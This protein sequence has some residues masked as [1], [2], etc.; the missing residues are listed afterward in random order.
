MISQI[1]Q[2]EWQ[3]SLSRFSQLSAGLS[4]RFLLPINRDLRQTRSPARNFN[5]D[6]QVEVSAASS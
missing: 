6:L 3:V 4:N 5:F 1:N 2:F